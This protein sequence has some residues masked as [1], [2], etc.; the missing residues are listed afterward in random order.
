MEIIYLFLYKNIYIIIYYNEVCQKS[1]LILTISKDSPP[2]ALQN[3][4][5]L[6]KKKKQY[7][8][9]WCK[10]LGDRNIRS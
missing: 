7:F 2:F 4:Y 1:N 3:S 8:E 6:K 10:M 5:A 9:H